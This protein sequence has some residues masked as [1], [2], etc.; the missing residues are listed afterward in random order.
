MERFLS[1]V[2]IICLSSGIVALGAA[3]LHRRYR[4]HSGAGSRSLIHELRGDFDASRAGL[5]RGKADG[6]GKITLKGDSLAQAPSNDEASR[7]QVGGSESSHATDKLDSEDRQELNN[8]L[9]GI[10]P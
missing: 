6:P 5:R 4:G 2:V 10:L 7:W 9:D 3:E 8:M 1:Y